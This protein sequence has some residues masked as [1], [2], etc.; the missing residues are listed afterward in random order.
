MQTSV[1]KTATPQAGYSC[2]DLAGLTAPQ[3]FDALDRTLVQLLRKIYPDCTLFLYKGY[4]VQDS[5]ANELL[6][7]SARDAS[8]APLS[9]KKPLVRVIE[10]DHKDKPVATLLICGKGPVQEREGLACALRVYQNQVGHLRKASL[11]S[12]TGLLTRDLFEYHIHRVYAEL[13]Q[14]KRRTTDKAPY[15]ALAFIDIDNFKV[16]NDRYGHLIGD[17][18]LLLVSQLMKSTFRVEDV[19]FRFGGEEFIVILNNCDLEICRRVLERFRKKIESFSFPLIEHLTI[20]IGF[21]LIEKAINYDVVVSRA[22]RALY[23][24]KQHGK[25]GCKSYEELVE[26]KQLDP[27]LEKDSDVELF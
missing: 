18:V 12:L 25:N 19:L 24:V 26:Q 1:K 15:F 2:D 3:N 20:S 13:R 27:L 7:C 4:Y 14:A 5:N 9:C 11:D 6:A 22:D 17:E 16:I 10:D 23:H 21:T 8:A